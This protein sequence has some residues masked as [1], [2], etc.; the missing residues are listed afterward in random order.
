LNHFLVQSVHESRRALHGKSV[1][2]GMLNARKL[3]TTRDFVSLDNSNFCNSSS[4][5]IY[6]KTKHCTI[7]ITGR[8]H[9]SQVWGEHHAIG[10]ALRCPL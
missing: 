8:N 9:I 3:G 7:R 2:V 10:H 4:I 5:N 1:E 6:S